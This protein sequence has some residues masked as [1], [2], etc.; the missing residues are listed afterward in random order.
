MKN[1]DNN[2]STVPHTPLNNADQ[3]GSC[4]LKPPTTFE[5]QCSL[6]KGHGF[7]ISKFSHEEIISLLSNTNYYR[8]SG[9]WST[10]QVD[11]EIPKGTDFREVIDIAQFDSELRILIFEMISQIEI[12]FRTQLAYHISHQYGSAA[13][14][15]KSIYIDK[16]S[17]DLVDSIN[18]QIERAKKYKVPYIV[19]NEKKYQKIPAW[20]VVE[21]LDFGTQSRIYGALKNKHLKQSI[22]NSFNVR[23]HYLDSWIPN[24]T[25]IR[26]T[27]AHHARLYNILMTRR[28]KLYK[29]SLYIDNSRLFATIFILFHLHRSCFPNNTAKYMQSLRDLIGK[30][31]DIDLDPLGI[32]EDWGKILSNLIKGF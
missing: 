21:V 20:V 22:A 10:L 5:E 12:K 2:I 27:C 32:P 24:L 15:D 6:L 31:D 3:V 4:I 14:T 19:H 30:Y 23:S 29:D 17:N 26:N 11:N 9:Y 1:I 25:Y 16:L 18:K 28:P 8:L 13:L 7:D